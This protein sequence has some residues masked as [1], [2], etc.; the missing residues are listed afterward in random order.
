MLTLEGGIGGK[1]F[2]RPEISGRDKECVTLQ[3]KLGYCYQKERG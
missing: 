3:R 1:E 2:K